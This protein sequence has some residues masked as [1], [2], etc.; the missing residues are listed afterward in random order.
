MNGIFAMIILLVCPGIS[1]PT[2]DVAL[3]VKQHTEFQPQDTPQLIA[4][5]QFDPEDE[6]RFSTDLSISEQC[7]HAILQIP[8][9]Q[10]ESQQ[11]GTGFPR[12]CTIVWVTAG[13]V[14]ASSED[15]VALVAL[16]HFCSRKFQSKVFNIFT[17]DQDPLNLAACCF[18][19]IFKFSQVHWRR[20]GSCSN[21]RVISWIRSKAY[22]PRLS[23]HAES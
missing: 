21:R 6:S 15:G 19:N 8:R 20:L 9:N 13:H 18:A 14:K 4:T 2:N 23:L 16:F 17:Q 10:V 1:I 11:I 5:I 12:K 3:L 7:K 22:G